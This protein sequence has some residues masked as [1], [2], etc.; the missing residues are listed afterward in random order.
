L[1]LTDPVVDFFPM[2][3]HVARRIDADAN[4]PAASEA[5]PPARSIPADTTAPAHLSSP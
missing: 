5:Q 3:G 1:R 4:L 2:H